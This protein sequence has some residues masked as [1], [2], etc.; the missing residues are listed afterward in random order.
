MSF[1]APDLA[2]QARD[3]RRRLRRSH[4][5]RHR[6]ERRSVAL[7]PV[8]GAAPHRGRQRWRLRRPPSCLRACL[9]ACGKKGPPLAPLR[10]APAR[11]HRL[12][13]AP[14]R[15]DDLRADHGARQ[16]RQRH[17]A[18]RPRTAGN[19]RVHRRPAEALKAPLANRML[20]LYATQVATIEVGPPPCP[21]RRPRRK[22]RARRWPWRP[23]RPMPG[24]AGRD[25][26]RH[27]ERRPG[28]RDAG[29]PAE[30]FKDVPPEPSR[31]VEREVPR[32]LLTPPEE[33]PPVRYYTVVGVGRKGQRGASDPAR[34][35]ARGAAARRPRRR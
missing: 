13:G 15:L 26:H 27:R 29:E 4:A 25:H 11:G 28:D 20:P 34:R 21:S 7:H 10:L 33:L 23:R 22:S 3:D 6:Q 16:E 14:H 31:R 2:A 30:V 32:P 35:A 18:G 19:A 5:R 8:S 24:R 17:H 12:R 9:S 1:D